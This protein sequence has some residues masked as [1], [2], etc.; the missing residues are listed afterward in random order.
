MFQPIKKWGNDNL[1]CSSS[2][3]S[4]GNR[5]CRPSFFMLFCFKPLWSY[6]F[7]DLVLFQAAW[8]KDLSDHATSPDQPGAWGVREGSGWCL[9]RGQISEVLH[10]WH[11]FCFHS[12]VWNILLPGVATGD[13]KGKF[14]GFMLFLHTSTILLFIAL[15]CLPPQRC[16]FVLLSA[17]LS[18]LN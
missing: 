17:T 2:S 12:R 14:C 5:I 11:G 6:H 15:F 8:A 1:Q 13:F 10:R 4:S 16:F 18:P 3:S 9:R 7:W